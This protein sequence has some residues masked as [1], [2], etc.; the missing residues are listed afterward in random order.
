MVCHQV[1]FWRESW[2]KNRRLKK[3]CI[4]NFF[5][6][7]SLHTNRHTDPYACIYCAHWTTVLLLWFVENLENINY[8][9][10]FQHSIKI[11]LKMFFAGDI[12][13]ELAPIMACMRDPT[14]RTFYLWLQSG[15]YFGQQKV[16]RLNNLSITTTPDICYGSHG[17]TRVNFFWPV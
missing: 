13:A 2:C 7:H 10:I 4:S 14:V 6:L 16:C 3:K 9:S 17:N 11:N 15:K 12:L 5:F 1:H 8:A